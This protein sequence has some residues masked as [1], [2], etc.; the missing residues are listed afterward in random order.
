MRSSMTS[1]DLPKALKDG[2]M[3]FRRNPDAGISHMHDDLPVLGI[4]F[5][6]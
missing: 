5:D 2:G 1:I 3:V 6:L 4:V